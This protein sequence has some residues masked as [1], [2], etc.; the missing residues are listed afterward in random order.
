MCSFHE[1]K[2]KICSDLELILKAWLTHSKPTKEI[3]I[4]LAV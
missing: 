1:D 4:I 3:L 2:W